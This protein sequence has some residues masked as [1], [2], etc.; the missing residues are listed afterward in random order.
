MKMTFTT[1]ER[2]LFANVLGDIVPAQG[3]RYMYKMIDDLAKSLSFTE[4]ELK[5]IGVKTGGEEFIDDNGK[6]II[7][8]PGQVMWNPKKDKEGEI[9]IEVPE[10][11]VNRIVSEFERQDAKHLLKKEAVPI[12]DK[13]I[14]ESQWDEKEGEA[15]GDNH[16]RNID[17]PGVGHQDDG[18]NERA[19]RRARNRR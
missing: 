14:A 4:K 18:R 2:L 11:L 9:T 8:E 7:V 17:E 19:H 15:Q 6:K 16:A 12:F 10:F 1:M 3:N 13:F 5:K